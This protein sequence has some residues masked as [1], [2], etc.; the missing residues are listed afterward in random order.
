MERMERQDD[1]SNKALAT[2][3]AAWHRVS[4]C[5]MCCVFETGMAAAARTLPNHLSQCV[6]VDVISIIPYPVLSWRD[7]GV[8]CVC[9]GMFIPMSHVYSPIPQCHRV[10]LHQS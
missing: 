2:G 4:V 9:H 10:I 6:C 1:D 8:A 3:M 7:R 5:G